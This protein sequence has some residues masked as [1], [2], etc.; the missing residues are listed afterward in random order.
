[1]NFIFAMV[2]IAVYFATLLADEATREQMENTNAGYDEW[3]C[4]LYNFQAKYSYAITKK[5]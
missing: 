4:T 3:Q 5:Y 1:V 2:L